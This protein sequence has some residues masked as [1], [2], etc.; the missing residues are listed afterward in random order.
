MALIAVAEKE[1]IEKGLY[2]CLKEINK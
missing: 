2:T 1:T